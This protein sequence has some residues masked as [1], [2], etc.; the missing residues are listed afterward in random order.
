LSL[1]AV[2]AVVG[3]AETVHMTAAVYR[4][5]REDHV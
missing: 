1:P 4:P 5:A 2:A 3:V